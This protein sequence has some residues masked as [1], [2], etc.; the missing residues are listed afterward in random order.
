MAKLLKRLDHRQ[1]DV[2]L[3]VLALL[4]EISLLT[5]KICGK[6]D[7]GADEMVPKA[8]KRPVK[9]PRRK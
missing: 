8:K 4:L 9:K 2:T 5:Q 6:P 3:E 7:V 1:D